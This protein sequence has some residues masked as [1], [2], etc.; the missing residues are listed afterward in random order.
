M[1]DARERIIDEETGEVV[2]NPDG[3]DILGFIGFVDSFKVEKSKRIKDEEGIE[4]KQQF[5]KIDLRIPMNREVSAKLERLQII[6]EKP[7]RIGFEQLQTSMNL[8]SGDARILK[9]L[10]RVL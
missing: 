1:D 10:L 6:K 5:M 4:I 2:G 9:K 3:G 7:I 8:D